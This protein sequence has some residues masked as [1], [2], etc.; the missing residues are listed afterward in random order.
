MIKDKLVS[1]RLW[2]TIIS[3]IVFAY[4]AMK[5]KMSA[6]AIASILTAVFTNYFNRSDRNANPK[7]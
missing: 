7:T 4:C 2:L 6:E 3:G 1:G 5:G